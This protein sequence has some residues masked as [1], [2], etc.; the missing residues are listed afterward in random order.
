LRPCFEYQLNNHPNGTDQ[1]L[2]SYE[3]L[4]RYPTLKFQVTGH[5]CD[6][7]SEEANL[8]IGMKRANAIKEAFSDGGV[9]P[10]QI[11][12]FSKGEAEPMFPNTNEA[13]RRRNRRVVV[14]IE[15]WNI[16]N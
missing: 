12:T 5:T 14:V 4:S 9:A 1:P 3:V 6:I 13:N 15:D 7:G 10:G 2:V 16:G 8:E 11:A